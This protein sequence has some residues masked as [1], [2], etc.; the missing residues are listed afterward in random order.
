MKTCLSTGVC[1][2]W[3]LATVVRSAA[4][5]GFEAV[6]IHASGHNPIVSVDPDRSAPGSVRR[7]FADAGVELAG[8]ATDVQL[9]APA[10]DP[11]PA[12]RVRRYLRLAERLGSAFVRVLA[13]PDRPG[14]R[15]AVLGELV[16]ALSA[17]APVAAEHR[18]TLLLENCGACLSSGQMWYVLDAVA[19][20]YVRCCWHPARALAIGERPTLS[21]P[22]LNRKIGMVRIWDGR[23]DENGRLCSVELPGQGD[24]NVPRLIALLRGIAYDGGLVFDWPASR[25]LPAPPETVLPAVA[26]H[27]KQQIAARGQ[28]LSAY[29]GDKTAPR[30]ADP[31]SRSFAGSTQDR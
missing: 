14:P 28:V 5:A 11:Q 21:V 26:T 1:P 30:Y 31:S 15:D 19:H 13:G 24:L 27:L 9:P 18:V 22:R 3:D 2:D 23:F 12:E 25:P 6:E 16:R 20:P 7:A 4:A 8:I 17:L 29:R 10:G